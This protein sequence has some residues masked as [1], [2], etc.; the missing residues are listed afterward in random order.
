MTF[1]NE[2]DFQHKEDK[3]GEILKIVH[4]FSQNQFR[5]TDAYKVGI[6]KK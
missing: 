1:S 3:N 4:E 6:Q 2:Q 5:Q